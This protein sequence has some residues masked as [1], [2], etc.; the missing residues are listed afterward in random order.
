V[1]ESFSVGEIAIL[2]YDQHGQPDLHKYTCGD[3]EILEFDGLFVEYRVAAPD[4]AT[5]WATP[6]VLRKKPQPPDWE[7]LATPADIQEPAHV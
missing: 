4:G 5:F 2:M 7:K 6:E 1:A 3:V